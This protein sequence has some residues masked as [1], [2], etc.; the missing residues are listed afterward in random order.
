MDLDKAIHKYGLKVDKIIKYTDKPEDVVIQRIET[1]QKYKNKLNELLKIPI[2]EQKTQPWYEAR[3]KVISASDFGQALNE[4]KFG[5]Q[6]DI[7]IKKVEPVE[8]GT[9]NNPFF[10]WGNMFEQ[11]ANDVYAKMHNLK[12]HEFGLLFHPTV[13][14]A[15]AS[16][17]SISELGIMLEIKCPLKRKIYPGADAPTQ[18]YYQIQ[19]QLDVCDLD[20]CDYFECEF[21]LCKSV[22]EFDA[23]TE[24]KGIFAKLNDKYTYG[25]LVLKDSDESMDAIETFQ[26]EQEKLGARPMYWLLKKYNLKRIYRD[27]E[28]IKKVLSDLGEVWEKILYYRENMDAFRKDMCKSITIETE[29]ANLPKEPEVVCNIK[30]FAFIN[31]D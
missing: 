20:E 18:Y 27:K 31:M 3:H 10:E 21:A 22:W 9:L 11:V 4:G 12:M 7:I 14:Y 15:A 23:S 19:G 2:I 8:H 29:L 5:T 25:P 17:D 24:T 28:F 1:I 30:P 13:N 16:P 6:R 26:K